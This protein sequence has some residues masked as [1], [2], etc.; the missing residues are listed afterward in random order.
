MEG[1]RAKEGGGL[2]RRAREEGRG[3]GDRNQESGFPVTVVNKI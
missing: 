2:E 3:L 1:R